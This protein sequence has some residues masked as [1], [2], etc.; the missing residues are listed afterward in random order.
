MDN[1]G[2][3]S[4]K[5]D[6]SWICSF[7]L[8]F[9]KLQRSCL[10]AL[11]LLTISSA[12]ALAEKPVEPVLPAL[13]SSGSILNELEIAF[14][15][16]IQ[17]R[18][19]GPQGNLGVCEPLLGNRSQKSADPIASLFIRQYAP[20]QV[21][22]SFKTNSFYYGSPND[23]NTDRLA[24]LLL[25][26]K[27]STP[28]S[29]QWLEGQPLA[30]NSPEL[31][32]NLVKVQGSYGQNPP[33]DA[34][35][36]SVDFK[37]NGVEIAPDTETLLGGLFSDSAFISDF[38]AATMSKGYPA[39]QAAYVMQSAVAV[40][41]A[42]SDPSDFDL[43]GNLLFNDGERSVSQTQFGSADFNIPGQECLPGQNCEEVPLETDIAG[44]AL[45]MGLGYLAYRR[46]QQSLREP[47]S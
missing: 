28:S 27:G 22:L 47:L 42:K 23:N 14:N 19:N 45:L 36:L 35:D 29:F 32:L 20:N 6:L 46:R 2:V 39:L 40:T 11:S 26:V 37:G 1:L 12:P 8:Y 34:F 43:D 44:G 17:G 7:W 38:F 4:I 31:A 15:C 13:V 16:G 25:N 9:M 3:N 21:A 18:A 30:N 5:G 10:F 24:R 33:A 41:Q